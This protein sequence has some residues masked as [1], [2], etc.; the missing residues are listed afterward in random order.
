MAAQNAF[1]GQEAAFQC[2]MFFNGFNPVMGAGRIETAARRRQGGDEPL[3]EAE[4]FYQYSFY[5]NRLLL[6]IRLETL[7]F[8]VGTL[9]VLIKYKN[10]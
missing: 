5:D 7:M 6:S 9:K 2:T 4:N 10:L 8:I 1:D 3:V